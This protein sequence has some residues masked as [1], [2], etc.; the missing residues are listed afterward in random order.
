MKRGGVQEWTASARGL[1]GMSDL[2]DKDHPVLQLL[3]QRRESESRPGSRDPGDNAKLGLAVEGGGMRGVVSAAMLACLGD[4]GLVHAFDSVYG[5]SSG[6]VNAA[7]FL[8]TENLWYP[9]S[10]YYEDLATNEFLSYWRAITGRSMLDLNFAYDTVVG[11]IKPLDYDKVLASPVELTI[12]I[13]LVDKLATLPAT[14][15][16]SK[17]ELRSALI[18]SAW[19]PLAVRGTGEY[20]GERAIDGG[21]FTALPFHLAV[22]DGCTHVL[23]LSTKPMSPVRNSVTSVTRFAV[24]YLNG[25]KK[26]LGDGYLRAARQKEQDRRQFLQ[27]RLARDAGGGPHILDLSPL[28]GSP[29]I[30]RSEMNPHR[31]LNAA[32]SAYAVSY[33]A[34]EGKSSD[35]VTDGRI[36]ALPRLAIVERAHEADDARFV[37]HFPSRNAVRQQRGKEP[38]SS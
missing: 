10:I 24:G 6:A 3:R 23:S 22:A 14:G 20:R 12:G 25:L 11:S 2:W 35:A 18:A 37:D 27:T 7:Y 19:M 8:T 21:I 30:R 33:A 38:G 31:L 26:G 4:R 32:R 16:R 34:I 29:E 28:P 9:A 17:E 1:W 36:R 5:S 13:T 15:F